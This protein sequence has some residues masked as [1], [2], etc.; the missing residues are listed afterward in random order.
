[1]SNLKQ[2]TSPLLSL[3]LVVQVCRAGQTAKGDYCWTNQTEENMNP[4]KLNPTRHTGVRCG[5]SPLA[6]Q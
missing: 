6:R 3:V 2:V 5:T 4:R 1:M